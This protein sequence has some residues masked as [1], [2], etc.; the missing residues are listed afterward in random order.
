MSQEDLGSVEENEWGE[1]S[2]DVGGTDGGEENEDDGTE[3]GNDDMGENA[4]NNNDVNDDNNE[5]NDDGNN[6]DNNNDGENKNGNDSGKEEKGNLALLQDLALPINK[7]GIN[8]SN[9]FLTFEFSI[10]S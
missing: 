6:D 4:S 1:E 9:F 8:F 5:E 10:L 3:V 2:V 7:T